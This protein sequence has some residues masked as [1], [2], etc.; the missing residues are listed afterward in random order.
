[1]HR[2]KII[3][4]DEAIVHKAEI[5]AWYE[6]INP[7]LALRFS[8]ELDRLTEKFLTKHPKIGHPITENTRKMTT[9]TFQYNIFYQID[10]PNQMI[11][12]LAIRHQKRDIRV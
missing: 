10:E 3:F 2:Y 8:D 4:K 11:Q 7:E 9:K 12:I 1:M 5:M 6:N